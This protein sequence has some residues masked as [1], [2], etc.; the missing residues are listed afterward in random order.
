MVHAKSNQRALETNIFAPFSRRYSKKPHHVTSYN[1]TKFIEPRNALFNTHT[2]GH[3]KQHNATDFD[4]NHQCELYIITSEDKLQ[5]NILYILI[6]YSYYYYYT[7]KHMQQNINIIYGIQIII[8]SIL[9][10]N[11]CVPNFI[12]S[13]FIMAVTLFFFFLFPSLYLIGARIRNILRPP[14]TRTHRSRAAN[15]QIRILYN[16]FYTKLTK[17]ALLK[18][19]NFCEDRP[20]FHLIVLKLIEIYTL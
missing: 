7:S 18:L 16:M 17:C 15:K 20:M 8:T 19:V 6:I 9:Y 11:Q 13:L 10:I 4:F 2:H 3:T 1:I 5:N 12:D 14:R